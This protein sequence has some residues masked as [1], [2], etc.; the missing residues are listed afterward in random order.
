[1][2]LAADLERYLASLGIP[3]VSLLVSLHRSWPEIA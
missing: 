2:P 3:Q 1:M